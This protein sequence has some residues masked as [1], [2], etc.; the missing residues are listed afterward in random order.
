MVMFEDHYNFQNVVNSQGEIQ[1][2]VSF[3][4]IDP[5]EEFSITYC[6]E[7]NNGPIYRCNAMGHYFIFINMND[8][9]KYTIKIIYKVCNVNGCFYEFKAYNEA[10]KEV[11]RNSLQVLNGKFKEFMPINKS[12]YEE[13]AVNIKLSRRKRIIE[14]SD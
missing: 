11:G 5:E 1:Y 4:P 3:K 10:D 6:G 7:E 8:G 13:E 14:N 2:I 9:T 12:H